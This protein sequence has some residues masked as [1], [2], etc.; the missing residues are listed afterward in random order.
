MRTFPM[1]R[2]GLEY[3]RGLPLTLTL[4]LSLLLTLRSTLN[5]FFLVGKELPVCN[6]VTD[7]T[8]FDQRWK[9]FSIAVSTNGRREI[10]K[11][12]NDA[13]QLLQVESWSSSSHLA[14][15]VGRAKRFHGTLH[16]RKAFLT[17]VA[18]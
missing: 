18:A 10:G 11:V 16:L 13:I 17:I 9:E 1:M 12:V 5:G 3:G 14:L 7:A 4:T 15:L 8:S 2:E 6:A